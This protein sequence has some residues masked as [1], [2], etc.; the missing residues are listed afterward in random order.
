MYLTQNIYLQNGGNIL[1]IHLFEKRTIYRK[2][3]VRINL[4]VINNFI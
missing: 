2:R 4:L 3:R 1:T